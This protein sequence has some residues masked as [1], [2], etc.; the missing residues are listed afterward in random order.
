MR[1]IHRIF[2]LIA[3]M[4][5]AVYGQGGGGGGDSGDGGGGGG[6]G[7]IYSEAF[8]Q[9]LIFITFHGAFYFQVP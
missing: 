6:G 5:I 2:L 4:E 7:G 9:A 3:Y 8:S 1:S